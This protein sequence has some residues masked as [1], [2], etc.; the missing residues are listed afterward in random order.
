VFPLSKPQDTPA[1]LPQRKLQ[2]IKAL[3]NKGIR[4]QEIVEEV[5]CFCQAVQ[6]YKSNMY[7]IGK[8]KKEVYGKRGKPFDLGDEIGICFVLLILM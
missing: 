2:L 3:L 4:I 8:I 6:Y 7:N 1:K 5:K